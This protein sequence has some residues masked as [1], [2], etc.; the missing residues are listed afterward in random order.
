MT[1]LSARRPLRF[2]VMCRGTTF[3]AWQA[4]CLRQ[5]LAVEDVQPSLLIIEEEDA[6][7][8][9]VRGRIRRVF[10]GATTFW[11]LYERFGLKSSGA[12]GVVDLAQMFSSVPRLR[13]RVFRKGYS[14]YFSEEDLARVRGHD[15][16][17]ILRFA[18]GI[19]RGG[20]LTAAR[21][22]VWSFHHGDEQ[23]YRGVP[24]C[25]WEIYRGDPVTGAILQRVTERLDAGV[26][27]H[28]GFLRTRNT[29]YRRHRDAAYFASAAWPARVC[30]D[31]RN[32]VAA[33]LDGPP[34]QT[35]A[36]ILRR[37]TNI[38]VLAFGVRILRARVAE[39]LRD[40]FQADH[41]NVGLIRRPIRSLLTD[42]GTPDVSW[43][44]ELPRGQYI[45]DPFGV[46]RDGERRILVEHYDYRRN[47]GRV[48][49]VEAWTNG[50]VAEPTVALRLGGHASYPCLFE[51][52]DEIYC[53]PET[54][55]SRR[56]CLYRAL[57]FPEAWVEEACLVSDFAAA[58][59]TIFRYGDRWWLLCVN[60][61]RDDDTLFAWY[62]GDLRGPWSPHAANPLKTDPRCSRP[63]G[64]PF[65]VDGQL[66]RPAM[67]NS[68]TYGGALAINRVRRL[69]PV[70]FDEEV[71]RIVPPFTG[72]R[73]AKG[74]HT[75][76]A[77][78]EWTLVDGKS[79]YFYWAS[80][81]RA[82]RARM[83]PLLRMMGLRLL[84]LAAAF[85]AAAS[86]A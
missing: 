28:K 55:G 12:L 44:P 35:T 58:D 14:E 70:E 64:R 30:K 67:D 7:P 9:S 19:L 69:T 81:R 52:R 39:L 62:A 83:P 13:C 8:P 3:A 71:V 57:R 17:F 25:F 53:V 21:Y 47:E 6:E 24:P 61:D 72:T 77:W 49:V 45:A 48:A 10:P 20:I 33:Y 42:V 68:R 16:D 54:I 65:V 56:V 43:L 15:L 34:S 46:S 18:F 66:Y 79:T 75:L 60:H 85:A 38:Q 36:P 37:P 29:S 51:D 82:L 27:L 84:A 32:G 41:W 23:K 11:T 5:L 78:G 80:F 86:R 4:V 63:A 31:L 2:G 26:V 74:V 59:P 50:A 76:S 22:G 40:L 73:Y 1:D